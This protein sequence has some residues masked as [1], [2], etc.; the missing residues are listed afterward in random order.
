MTDFAG[1]S[2]GVVRANNPQI[3]QELYDPTRPDS[4]VLFTDYNSLYP[5]VMLERPLTT[6]GFKWL[7]QYE[8][9]RLD[10]K[11]I[12]D[13]W[14]M[15]YKLV[16]DMEIPEDKYDYYDQCPMMPENKKKLRLS[17]KYAVH[18]GTLKCYIRHGLVVKHVHNF[19]SFRLSLLL[20]NFMTF[21]THK[22]IHAN[23]QFTKCYIKA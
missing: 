11:R 16:V 22:R 1:G 10:I 17:T 9:E 12:P 18:Y 15:G 21:T 19:I 13:D 8:I 2:T 14:D 7:S 5:A 20:H 4:Y 6:Y 3:S 23:N